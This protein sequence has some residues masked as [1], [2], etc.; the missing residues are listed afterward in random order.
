GAS[1]VRA[2]AVRGRRLV[3]S[4][5]V[6]YGA[7]ENIGVACADVL[8]GYEEGRGARV[9]VAL[10][11]GFVRVKRLHGLDGVRDSRAASDA[12]RTNADRF[13]VGFDGGA[14]IAHARR[15]ANGGWEAAA[16]SVAAMNR[17]CE[18]CARAG[19]TAAWF[20]PASYLSISTSPTPH[21]DE[22]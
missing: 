1:T 22:E 2:V 17:I 11:S 14:E 21:P 12:A 15:A 8:S 9:A 10:G 20:V 5:S 7:I 4:G 18:G 19:Y 3:W 13:C 6:P 16:F